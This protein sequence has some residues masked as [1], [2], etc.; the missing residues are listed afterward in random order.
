M[1]RFIL[2]LS[3]AAL[4]GCVGS[5]FHDSDVANANKLVAEKKYADAAV[6][7]DKIA[8][9]ASG[10][11][12]GAVASF[13]AARLRASYDNP[14]RDYGSALQKFEDFL[15]RYPNNELA[16]DAQNWRFFLKTILELRRENEQ[17]TKNIQ[18]LQKIDVR[19]E[20][21]RKTK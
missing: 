14:H 20:E 12:R 11:E 1:K 4:S 15:R 9:D 2:V 13:S 21:R 8:K 18:Q 17:L 7:F 10:T 16:H 19:H 3:L 5:L 6:S